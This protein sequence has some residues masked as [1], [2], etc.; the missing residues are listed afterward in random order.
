M[1]DLASVISRTRVIYIYRVYRNIFG[2]KHHARKIDKLHKIF[3][4]Y[5][6]LMHNFQGQNVQIFPLYI[7]LARRINTFWSN[8]FDKFWFGGIRTFF[9]QKLYKKNRQNFEVFVHSFLPQ[10]VSISPSHI[11]PT[12]TSFYL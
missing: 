8:G 4:K 9:Y 7:L 12:C 1:V 6:L 2:E 10:I 11:L 5:Q 3:E